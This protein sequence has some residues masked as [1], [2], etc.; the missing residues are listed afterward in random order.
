MAKQQHLNQRHHALH[1]ASTRRFSIVHV[2]MH[3]LLGMQ[4]SRSLRLFLQA[5]LCLPAMNVVQVNPRLKLIWQL[6]GA[7]VVH[8]PQDVCL[9]AH[10]RNR[11]PCIGDIVVRQAAEL[12]R[13][14]CCHPSTGWVKSIRKFG[15]EGIRVAVAI[16]PPYNAASEENHIAGACK[17]RL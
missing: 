13:Y 14:V 3:V 15:Q 12:I 7:C 9:K 10:L 5:L 1:I 11:D 4:S 8:L 2:L 16:I 17:H 6:V